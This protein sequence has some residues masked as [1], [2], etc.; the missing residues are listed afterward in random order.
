MTDFAT[1]Y[2]ALVVPRL[3]NACRLMGVYLALDMRE[4]GE[5]VSDVWS[6]ARRYGATHLPGALTAELLDWI[7]A[8]IMS[9]MFEA[10]R[11]LG[12][13]EY[14]QVTMMMVDDGRQLL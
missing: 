5:A 10:E 13:C 3:K 9:A 8:E 6:D 1:T 4:W 14:K 2:R 11:L 12:Q 7:E